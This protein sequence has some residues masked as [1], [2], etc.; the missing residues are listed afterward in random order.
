M[1]SCV[2]VAADRISDAW[3]GHPG[4]VRTVYRTDISPESATGSITVPPLDTSTRPRSCVTGS[5]GRASEQ[6][7]YG[8]HGVESGTLKALRVN[9]MQK[10]EF[11]TCLTGGV[12]AATLPRVSRGADISSEGLASELINSENQ[13]RLAFIVGNSDYPRDQRIFPAIKN[14]R[15]IEARLIKLGFN[16]VGVAFDADKASILRGVEQLKTQIQ[17]TAPESDPIIVVYF[18]GHGFQKLG[19]NLLVP[20]GLDVS[21]KDLADKCVALQTEIIDRLPQRY[22]GLT[23]AIVDAC[24][25][26][27]DAGAEQSFNYTN[28]PVGCMLAFSAS[29]GQ[30]SL[31]P[32]DVEQNTF[33]TAALL[34]SIDESNALTS[35]NDLF[36]RAQLRTQSSME[37]HSLEFVRKRAQRP[38]LATGQVGR[39][40][41]MK[42]S[43]KD[44]ERAQST[45]NKPELQAWKRVEDAL[46]PSEIEQNA[47]HLI[48]DYPESSFRGQAEV[49]LQG[50]R[51]A[52]KAFES[53][54][55]FLRI[56]GLNPIAGDD[57]Y[58]EDVRKAL[59]GDKDAAARIGSMYREGSNGLP[60]NLDRWEQ[61]LQY[62]SALG[63]A[64]AC[65]ELYRKYRDDG[66]DGAATYYNQQATKLG[67]RVAG[68]LSSSRSGIR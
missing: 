39:F 35:I 31:A 66:R 15:D 54:N 62:A 18:C 10:R 19:R 55:V 50:A 43:R 65:Y 17:S 4:T 59:R 60:Q 22:P 3:K 36:V 25:S 11:L 29:A 23:I 20:A 21:D 64:I 32:R 61:W 24:R 26:S 56:S 57:R 67:L 12:L 40:T 38:H 2:G 1:R 9:Q 34:Q 33:Y 37:N 16:I 47:R 41:L 8:Y 7:G 48:A 63:N 27:A 14:A 13:L 42:S 30:V 52:Q 5:R 28:A 6:W 51:D 58:K 53:R 68:E 46:F 45:L 49:A 44:L